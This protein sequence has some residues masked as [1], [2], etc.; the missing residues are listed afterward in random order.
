[1]IAPLH[2]SVPDAPPLSATLLD[3]LRA[4]LL[5]GLHARAAEHAEHDAGAAALTS[6]SDVD[7]RL[8]RAVAELG[9]RR[10][11]QA[12]GEI[13]RALVRVDVGTYGSGEACGGS[14]AGER[15]E[16]IPTPATA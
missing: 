10:A 7:S 14:V 4:R 12:M 3:D 9:A 15:L 11:Q 16:A 2:V 8:E 1:M 13:E 6:A 5:A